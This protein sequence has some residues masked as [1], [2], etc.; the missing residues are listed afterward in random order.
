VN[1]LLVDDEQDVR[2]SLAGFLSKLGH[3][4]TGAAN[5]LEG[6]R[7]FHSQPFDLVITDIRMPGMDGLELLQRIKEIERSPVDM[8]IITGHGD[9]DNAVKALKYGAFDYLQKPV[10]VRELAITIERSAEYRQLRENYSQLKAEFKERVESQTRVYRGAAEQLRSAYLRE[11]GLGDIVVRSEAMRKVIH[12]AERYSPDRSVAVLI[13]GE[14]GTGKELVARYT[15]YYALGSAYA[16]FVAINCG[17]IAED[18][19]EA[20]LFGHEP[21]A[22]TGATPTGRMGKLEAAHGGTLFLDEIGEMPFPTQVKLLR[23]LEEKRFYRVGGVKEIP[24]DVRIIS[25]TNKDLWQEVAAKRFRQDLYY[26]INTGVIRIPPL[27]ERREGVVPLA[28]HFVNRA[29]SRRGKRFE[30]FAPAAERLLSSFEWPG[31]VRQL[32]NVME[33][34]ALLGPWDRVEE[35]DLAP[36]LE[37]GSLPVP[38]PERPTVIGPDGFELPEDPLDLNRL[39]EEIIRK[40]LKRFGGNQTRAAQYLGL[41]RRVLQGRLKKMGKGELHIFASG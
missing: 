17:A 37:S 3:R 32:K 21:G 1:I 14:T 8:I 9:M 11:I 31:N 30:G 4:V 22:Y 10:N 36:L 13:E 7:E 26:R 23:V 41:S 29:A 40:T 2:K 35:G 28:Q 39:N 16:P 18:L 20:E 25:A 6:L 12:L 34:L 24:V 33:R 5:G 15:H 38:T 27:R 19:F